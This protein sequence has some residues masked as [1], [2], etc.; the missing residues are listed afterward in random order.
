MPR[1][2]LLAGQRLWATVDSPR[3]RDVDQQVLVD[4]VAPL[5]RTNPPVVLSSH[6]PPAHDAFS[7][8][9]ATLPDA[10]DAPP[11]VG[12]DQA[13]LEQLLAQFGP[14]SV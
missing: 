5:R 1:D 8:L 13:A 6:L 4:A 3:V 10:P 11:F 2:E 12:P 14:A 9:L 7:Q